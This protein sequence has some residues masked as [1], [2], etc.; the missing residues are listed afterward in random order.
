MDSNGA[1]RNSDISFICVGTPSL[2][3]GK[4]DLSHVE[5]VS[6]E[7]ARGSQAEGIS[8]YGCAAEYGIARYD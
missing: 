3:S 2:R 5:H 1:V 4:I 8:S 6:G 7:I